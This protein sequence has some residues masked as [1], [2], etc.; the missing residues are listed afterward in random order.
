MR[1]IRA[2]P[3]YRELHSSMDWQVLRGVKNKNSTDITI[4]RCRELS[5]IKMARRS[6]REVSTAKWLRWI[7]KLSSIYQAYRNFLDGSR[8][9]REAIKL[10]SQKPWWIEITITAIEKGSSRGCR[11]CSKTDFQR[12]EKHRHE[13]NQ[14]YYLTKDP[15]NILSS[16]KHLSSRKMSSIKIQNTHT[17]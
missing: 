10:D 5:R 3:I 11:D 4:K 14:A 9:C 7:E 6:Y 13:C 12:R 1:E 17:H 16:Q 8:I 15:T 2:D